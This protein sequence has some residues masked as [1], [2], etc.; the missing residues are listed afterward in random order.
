MDPK[1]SLYRYRP[2]RPLKFYED[3]LN[4][5]KFITNSKGESLANGDLGNV[6]P[7]FEFIRE[8]IK[9][10]LPEWESY[11]E[12]MLRAIELNYALALEV[13]FARKTKHTKVLTFIN[14]MISSFHTQAVLTDPNIFDLEF[15]KEMG[16]L[17][18]KAWPNLA[19]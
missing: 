7:L 17:Q 13:D 10:T 18:Q 3:F 5:E 16:I 11:S 12:G 9:K 14:A 6:K 4:V 2:L 15:I 19:S 8:H 1:N